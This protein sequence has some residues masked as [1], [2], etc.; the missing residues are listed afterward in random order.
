MLSSSACAPAQI[1]AIPSWTT[2]GV[3]GIAR[4]TGTPAPRWRSIAAVGIAAAIESTVCS[5]WIS[6]PISPSSVSMSCGLTAITIR[7]APRAASVFDSVTAMP[8]R[9]RSSSARSSR[10]VEAESSPA[11]RQP[12]ESSPLTSASPI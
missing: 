10:L 2:A 12:E 3:F 6:G 1:P 11:F 4:T 5:G 7:A 8:C 9:S